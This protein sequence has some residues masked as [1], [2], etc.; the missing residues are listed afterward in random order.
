MPHVLSVNLGSRTAI[1]Q[2]VLG[3]TGGIKR[4]VAGPV[5]IAPVTAGSG[6][7][8]DHISDTRVHGGSDQAVY[9]YAREDLDGWAA[10]LGREIPA[11]LFG[12]NLT[13]VG[14]D[15]TDAVLGEKWRMGTAVIQVT[16]PRIP[17]RTFAAVMAEPGWIRTFTREGACGAYFRV[18]EAGAVAAGDPAELVERPDHGVTVRL[19]F[20]ALMTEPELLPRLAEAGPHL[21]DVLRRQVDRR[22][23][24][25]PA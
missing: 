23:A 14:V 17:C 8:G 4:P 19:A 25:D 18:V 13:T 9:A 16:N 22:T 2:S 24:P 7:A 20:R 1:D 6:L 3:H 15:L 5:E 10:R 21:T 11:G 12:E